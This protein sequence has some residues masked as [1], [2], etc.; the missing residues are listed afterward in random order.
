MTDPPVSLLG[1]ALTDD[2]LNLNKWPLPNVTI[3]P[4]GFLVV[5]ASDNN[6]TTVPGELHTNFKLDANGEYV[7]LVQN[8]STPIIASAFPAREQTRMFPIRTAMA[9]PMATK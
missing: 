1:W 6:R 2:E 7:A 3:A 8:P 9:L 5:F 4:G